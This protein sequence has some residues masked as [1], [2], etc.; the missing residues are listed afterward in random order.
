MSSVSSAPPTAPRREY[1]AILPFN[2]DFFSYSTSTS[3]G[4]TGFTTTGSLGGV[5]GATGDNCPAG[6]VLRENGKK[7]FP[8]ANP[9]VTTYMVGV[10]DATTFLNGYINPNSPVFQPMN[11]DKPTYLDDGV[12][13]GLYDGTSNIGP[14]VYTA[15]D[16]VVTGPQ[17]IIG[18]GPCLFD[19]TGA[20]GTYALLYQN[21]SDYCAAEAGDCSGNFAGIYSSGELYATGNIKSEKVVAGGLATVHLRGTGA[22]TLLSSATEADLYLD[23]RLGN[24]WKVTTSTSCPHLSSI[25]VYCGTNFE[26]PIAPAAGANY[27]LIVKNAGL[28]AAN[29]V[30]SGPSNIATDVPSVRMTTDDRFYTFSFVGDGTTL[31]QTAR[32]G[33]SV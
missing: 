21:S 29:L 24:T 25:Y 17:G 12:D 18:L 4:P 1:V 30:L 27:T 9:G 7:L 14:G 16:V 19:A 33:P 13:T 32:A 23:P 11:T 22:A 5:T 2:G 15:G 3:F 28:T 6:R 26:T 31:I 20:T 10:Y 8:E